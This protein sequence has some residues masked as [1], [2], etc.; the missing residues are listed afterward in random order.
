MKITEAREQ[1]YST[2]KHSD[3]KRETIDS[4]QATE[5]TEFFFTRTG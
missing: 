1:K 3:E 5:K 4:R 2:L